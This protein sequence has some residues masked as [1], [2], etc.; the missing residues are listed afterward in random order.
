MYSHN[1]CHQCSRM[2]TASF[3]DQSRVAVASSCAAF[4]S[5]PNAESTRQQTS[6]AG[7]GAQS[8]RNGG[9][10]LKRSGKVGAGKENKAAR[11]EERMQ[12]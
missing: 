6:L 4:T 10:V 7:I 2:P 3:N 8:S 1:A 12:K 9:G 5:D 11:R